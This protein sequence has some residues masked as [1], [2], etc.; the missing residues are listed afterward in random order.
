MG[1]VFMKFATRMAAL[2]LLG[3]AAPALLQ[4]TTLIK[5][6]M[7]QM[8]ES[9]TDIVV[10]TVSSVRSVWVNRTLMTLT[11]VAVSESLK[12]SGAVEVTVV[13][14]GG[15]DTNRAVPV[16]I[17]YPGSPMLSPAEEVVLFLSSDDSPVAN[18]LTVVGYSQGKFSVVRDGADF[19]LAQGMTPDNQLPLVALRE[20]VRDVVAKEEG[21]K[22]E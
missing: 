13:T 14:P 17:L 16:A 4:A 7:E 22:H 5:M 6:T 15:I 21:E 8:A 20:R 9:A 3:L 19:T 11:T 10:G 2:L 1:E 12:G 18:A